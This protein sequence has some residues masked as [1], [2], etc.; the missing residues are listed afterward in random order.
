MGFSGGSVVN[1]LPVMQEMGSIYGLGRSA[2][3]ENIPLQYFLG[4]P[5]DKEAW[6]AIVH[7]LTR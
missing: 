2:G 3:E 1:D 4:N 6:W 7:G 5:I